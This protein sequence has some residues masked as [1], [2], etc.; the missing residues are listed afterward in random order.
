MTSFISNPLVILLPPQTC[1]HRRL[2]EEAEKLTRRAEA[3]ASQWNFE[4]VSSSV[5]RDVD[6]TSPEDSTRAEDKGTRSSLALAR[7]GWGETPP[8]TIGAPSS[9]VGTR[10]DAVESYRNGSRVSSR[11]EPLHI[12]TRMGLGRQGAG[13]TSEGRGRGTSA[14]AASSSTPTSLSSSL[15]TD[16]I[17]RSLL[18]AGRRDE[19]AVPTSEGES[20]LDTTR[21]PCREPSAHGWARRWQPGV[22]ESCSV[23][24]LWED[25]AQVLGSEANANKA[26]MEGSSQDKV[27]TPE[28]VREAKIS[29][30]GII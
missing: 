6:P 22:P 28:E 14:G 21:T 20:S 7:N 5:D 26:Q 8:S 11:G 10:D 9:P 1:R 3:D 17:A 18:N 4:V 30:D 24:G 27:D 13:G 29:P 16:S 23:L 25:A 19:F 12:R 15:G 2:D